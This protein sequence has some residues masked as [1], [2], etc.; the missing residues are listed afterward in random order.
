MKS[1]F[2]LLLT[3]ASPFAFSIGVKSTGYII[4]H[5]TSVTVSEHGQCR[6]VHNGS[7]TYHFFIGARAASEWTSFLNNPPAGVTFSNCDATPRSC[8]DIKKRNPS[9]TSGVYTIDPDGM[10]NGYSA[11]QTYC[12]MDVDGGG[13]TLVWSNTRGGTNKPTQGLTWV[14]TT[15]SLPRCSQA[16]GAGTGCGYLSNSKDAFNYFVGI[17][18]WSNITKHNKNLEM[19]YEWSSAGSN[20]EQSTIFNLKRFS[21]STLYTNFAS[22]SNQLVGSVSPGLAIYHFTGHP[23]STIDVNNDYSTTSSCADQFQS[24][25]WF[26]FCW[27]GYI[28]GG[29]PSH[30]SY[31]N[32][33]YW[34]GSAP[35]WGTPD[36][37]GGGNGWIYVREYDLLSNCTEIK[38]K[39][40]NAP[41][42]QYWIDPDGA[43]GNTPLFAYC[44]MTTD[45]GGWT[46][47]MNQ[48][49]DTGGIFTSVG[50]ALNFNSNNPLSDRYSILKHTEQ[51]RALDN[52]FT[53]KINWPGYNSRNIWRQRSNP[54]VQGSV[55]GYIPITID[56]TSNHW[57]G[58][59]R[60]CDTDCTK[61]LIDGS[62]NNGD[63][64]YAV[65]SLISYGGGIPAHEGI[66]LAH[67]GVNQ[68]Q[69][70]VRDD[71]FLL[72]E[73]RDC[74]EILE[75][76]KSVGDGLYWVDPTQSGS[77]MPVYC[78]MTTDG[79][80]WTLVF[81]H[82]IAG[83]Y[84]VNNGV[85]P[86]SKNTSTPT[87]HLYSIL[88]ELDK[89]K[90]NNRYIFKIN[91]PGYAIRNIWAQTTN[92]A[93][94]QPVN[95]YVP[96]LID[97]TQNY[98]GG[99][100]RN[101]AVACGSSFIDGSVGVTN[102]HY[103][104][105]SYAAYG[106]P[107]GIP[108][109]IDI[110]GGGVPHVQLWT[111]R[112]EGILT[113]RS[114]KEILDAGLSVGSGL[115]LIDPD[116]VGGRLPMRVYCDM[117]TDGGG[118]TR[119][120]YTQDA[121]ARAL[122][123][124]DFFVSEVEFGKIGLMGIAGSAASINPEWFSKL[125]GT[126][127][128][129]LYSPAYSA[130]PYIDKGFGTWDYDTPKCTGNLRHTG[131][132]AG[133]PGPGANDN[134]DT[135]DRFNISV[136]NGAEGIVPNY[137][138]ELCYSGKGNCAFSFYLR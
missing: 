39:F 75:Y 31:V 136:N 32:G 100:E 1:L 58:L 53:F 45:G 115:Y 125:V 18:H 83:G 112:A 66:R 90:S 67:E 61:S 121:A 8:L 7:S 29:G 107:A 19:M 11:F 87:A 13:W 78:D 88:G 41:D 85:D 74:Q 98:W 20:I 40:P 72:R 26:G 96:I 86:L 4:P 116:G 25:F 123:T 37:N 70:W 108:T 62:V 46:L 73:P 137:G 64:F 27:N 105:A 60:S 122:V 71:S 81:N 91:W 124:A 35:A 48:T 138:P 127:D 84:F 51:F 118:W 94:D 76:G 104:I 63:W 93:V 102:W 109:T 80:G 101:C 55:Q 79:G 110:T 21:E 114:C 15:R 47:L 43:G 33:A 69:L 17:N 50:E 99:L 22:N 14:E 97:T 24:P 68:T 52:L 36:G 111:R 82:N 117:V 77:S 130:A 49:Y 54:A 120:A 38:S 129:M 95:G 23:L 28:M 128:A 131:R 42:G 6:K 34:L 133:C 132:N 119:V 59:E 12:N 44:D 89:F 16:N 65:A 103:A 30:H 135:A 2:V 134:Y 126:T 57:G 113:K 3:L 56:S 92:P 5:G 10:S 9:A 106:T